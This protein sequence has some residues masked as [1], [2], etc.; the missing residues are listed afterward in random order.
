[1][2]EQ[3]DEALYQRFLR[4]D[5]RAFERLYS[6]YRQP[7]FAFLLH[8]IGSRADADELF[9]EV[10]IRVMQAG[11]GFRE[12]S[13][14][15]WVFRISRNLYI[16]L[17]RRRRV[18]PVADS[19]EIERVAATDAG[20]E[21]HTQDADCVGLLLAALNRLPQEQREAFLLK[22]ETG[23]RLKDIARLMHVGRETLKSRLRY[24]MKRLRTAV[25]DC[26]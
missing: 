13:F 12:G 17:L 6:R 9:Q 15:A 2:E 7:V 4:G 3:T 18:R 20:P 16:D 22:E 11:D 10:W 23:T 26:L 8:S 24:A 21:R 1:M 14:R 25:E 5:I 19:R